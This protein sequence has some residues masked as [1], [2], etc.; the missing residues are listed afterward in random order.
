MQKEN[1]TILEMYKDGISA[2]E[3]LK[4]YKLKDLYNNGITIQ[5]FFKEGLTIRELYDA[6]IT[7]K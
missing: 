7:I 5:N 2:R 6:G 4:Y 3:L 1:I